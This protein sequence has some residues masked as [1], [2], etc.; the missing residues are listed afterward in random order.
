[1]IDSRVF[2]V[3]KYEGYGRLVI[4]QECTLLSSSKLFVCVFFGKQ[5]N[6][7][8]IFCTRKLCIYRPAHEQ[9]GHSSM[10]GDTMNV[11]NVFN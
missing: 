1:M 9:A 2:T 8:L 6:A 5:R 3:N 10:C 11:K 7:A 4:L